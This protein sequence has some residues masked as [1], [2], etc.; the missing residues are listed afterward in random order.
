MTHWKDERD[1]NLLFAMPPRDDALRP[2]RE[3]LIALWQPTLAACWEALPPARRSLGLLSDYLR[4]L[5]LHRVGQWDWPE[6]TAPYDPALI[7]RLTAICQ[8]TIDQTRPLLP[9]VCSEPD[10]P[11]HCFLML[12]TMACNRFIET[13]QSSTTAAQDQGRDM[14]VLIRHAPG[15]P[16][17]GPAQAALIALCMPLIAACWEALRST[18]LSR[19]EF[20]SLV[21]GLV[22]HRLHRSE[23]PDYVAGLDAQSTRRLHDRAAR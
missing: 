17:L 11:M 14:N 2:M 3:Q 19:A 12:I 6:Q 13:R 1:L 16:V 7:E 18:P 9:D 5:M 21:F 4:A 20:E 15:D 22:N 8:P 10:V 23:P